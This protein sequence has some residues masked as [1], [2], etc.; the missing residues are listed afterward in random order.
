MKIEQFED[1]NLSHYSYIILDDA[2]QQA[3]VIDP[4]RDPKPYYDFVKQH[5]ARIIGV[6]ETH[7]HADFVSSH[8]E[9]QKHTGARIYASKLL[10]AN[11]SVTP[12]DDGDVLELGGVK[13]KAMNTPGH[14][15]DSISLVLEHE[16]KDKAVF[17]GDTLFIGDCGR[18]DLRELGEDLSLKR[19]AL[20]KKMYSSL[21][22]KLMKLD[23]AVLVYPAHGAGTLCGKALSKASSST[24]GAEKM[25]NWSLQELSEDAFVTA[26]TEDQPFVPLYFPYDVELNKKGAP[27]FDGNLIQHIKGQKVDSMEMVAG[28][29]PG[30]P[31]I[32]TRKSELYKK[33]HLKNAI[34]IMD[35]EK[36]E[37]WLGTLVA[38]GDPFYL[39]GSDE[40]ALSVLAG[41]IAKIG[42]EPFIKQAFVLD[43][44]PEASAALNMEAFRQDPSAYTIVD[45]RNESESKSQPA[46]EGSYN[47]PL[48]ELNERYHELPVDKPIVVHCAGGYRSA[49]GSSILEDKLNVD[50]FDLGDNIKDF[51]SAH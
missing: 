29:D 34:N 7:P 30:I 9:I 28:L 37:T 31:I 14:S 17:T 40:E 18:P 36:F 10:D 5:N 47:I 25:S 33:Q 1:K 51:I 6:I 41:R 26:L 44:G 49:A 16:G 46:F 32:D 20:A 21:R 35:G 11:Y 50:V 8:L 2:D 15:P 4:S 43:F 38:P 45:I 42:Y 3:V 22:E 48:P 19:E 27:D 39:A 12:F 23:D 24:I 13:L